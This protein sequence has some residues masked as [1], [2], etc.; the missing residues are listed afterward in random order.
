MFALVTLVAASAWLPEDYEI[1]SLNDKVRGDLGAT[2]T[3][4]SWLGVDKKSDTKEI[5][6]AYKKLLRRLHPDKVVGKSP[7][8]KAE[9]R[10]QRLSAVAEILRNKSLRRRYDYFLD[11]G[12]PKWKGT[13]YYYSKYR[14]GLIITILGL[15]LVSGLV[16]FMGLKINAKQD[17]KRLIEFK[18][19]IKD[20]AWN[21]Q[22]FP[23]VDG[24]DRK[25]VNE[26]TG[27]QFVVNSIGD[28]FAVDDSNDDELVLLDESR[29]NLSPSIKDTL[30]IRMP[31]FFWNFSV[32]KILPG[33]KVSLAKTETHP[34]PSS[35]N[36]NTN[37][38]TKPKSK[39]KSNKGG[40]KIELPNGKVIY[41]RK[42]QQ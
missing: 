33:L 8:K 17:F 41:S 5:S 34:E 21:G 35:T 29:I 12:F 10:F 30:I 13:G 16:H 28:V 11:N 32:G 1:F 6:K 18:K 23:P 36:N 25:V 15:Y 19:V 24:S 40:K 42:K 22:L 3:F 37:S 14:P 20:Q 26:A 27:R 7:R 2:I 31:I 38:N 39:K 9:E 4:Y